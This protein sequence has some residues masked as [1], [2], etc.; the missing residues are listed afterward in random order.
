MPFARL[1]TVLH[2]IEYVVEDTR[3]RE[4]IQS[5][6]NILEARALAKEAY[7]HARA[8]EMR[9][10]ITSSARLLGWKIDYIQSF[11]LDE[12]GIIC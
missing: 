5:A 8:R 4:G 3:P 6:P 7:Y 9:G 2:P 10:K 12:E 1:P 11:C